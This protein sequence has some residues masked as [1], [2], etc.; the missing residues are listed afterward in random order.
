[1]DDPLLRRIRWG[2]VARVAALAL[3]ALL[4]AAWPRLRSAP[5]SLP[6]A[7]PVPVDPAAGRGAGAG[8][9]GEANAVADA[10][11]AGPPAAAAV[12]PPAGVDTRR[13]PHRPPRR[14]HTPTRAPRADR[15]RRTPPP[16]APPRPAVR[17][18]ARAVPRAAVPAPLPRPASAPV[19]LRRSVT[20]PRSRAPRSDA[21]AEFA[22]ARREF[23]RP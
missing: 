23:G 8:A 3:L 20:P 1:M 14:R 21:A 6:A 11:T 13:D 5:P 22:P 16:S 7:A 12:R 19:R 9:A 4:V 2:N 10:A 17:R 18:P 15:P